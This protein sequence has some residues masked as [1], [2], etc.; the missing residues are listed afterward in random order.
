[1]QSLSVF[2]VLIQDGYCTLGSLFEMV[3][4]ATRGITIYQGRRNIISNLNMVDDN[5]I[6]MIKLASAF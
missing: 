5:S 2:T 1:M 3:F 4:E 6:V